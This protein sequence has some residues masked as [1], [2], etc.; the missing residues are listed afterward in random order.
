MVF[1]WKTPANVAIGATDPPALLSEQV[2]QAVLP[3]STTVA[4]LSVYF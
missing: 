3:E 1:H 2:C 4:K